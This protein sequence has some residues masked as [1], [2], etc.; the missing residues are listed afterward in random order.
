MPPCLIVACS[1]LIVVLQASVPAWAEENSQKEISLYVESG[2][3]HSARSVA[4]SDDDRLIA[5]G[6]LDRTIKIWDAHSSRELMTLPNDKMSSFL[7]FLPRRPVLAS[8]NEDGTITVWDIETGALI[9]SVMCAH[10]GS[11]IA[12]ADS[13]STLICADEVGEVIRRWNTATFEELSSMPIQMS[14]KLTAWRLSTDGALIAGHNSQ[15]HFE[16]VNL[17]TWKVVGRLPTKKP[18]AI[19]SIAFAREGGRV[20]TNE[21]YSSL[22]AWQWDRSDGRPA[23]VEGTIEAPGIHAVCFS[24]DGQRVAY[25]SESGDIVILDTSAWKETGRLRS[26]SNRIENV[27]LARDSKELAIQVWYDSHF[28]WN[29]EKGALVT[30]GDT[31]ITYDNNHLFEKEGTL[32]GKDFRVINQQDYLRLERE[33]GQEILTLVLLDKTRNWVAV[34]PDGRFDTNMNLA[35]IAGVHW[36]LSGKSL[37]PLPLE[38]FMRDYYEPRLLPRALA[39]ELFSPLPSPTELNRAQPTIEIKPIEVEDAQAGLA[40]VTVEIASDTVKVL[41]EGKPVSMKSG[42]YDL[43]LFRNG[44]LVGQFPDPTDEVIAGE[45]KRD[46]VLAQWR[47]QHALTLDPKTGKQTVTFRGIKLPRTVGLKAVEFSAYAFNV[48]RVKSA[49]A[50][51]TLA[52]PEELTPR[53]GRAYVVTI[54]INRFE[55]NRMPPLT[56]AVND[57]TRLNAELSTRLKTVIDSQTGHP[58]FGETNVIPITL[59]TDFERETGSGVV[60][61]ATKQRIKAVID[62][63]AGKPVDRGWLKSIANAEQLMPAQP[64]DLVVIA[65]STHGDTDQNGEFYLMPSDLGGSSDPQDLWRHAISSEEL[66]AWL[67]PVDAGELVMIVDA[68]HSAATVENQEFKPGPMGSR[69]LGQLAFDKGMR[70][71]AAS[72]RDQYAL[73]TGETQQGLLSYALVREGLGERAADFQPEDGRIQLAEWLTYGVTRVPGLYED[74]RTGKLKPRAATPLNQPEEKQFISI[75][76]PALFDFARGRELTLMMGTR[77][78]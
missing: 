53:Q 61:H 35:D 27:G 16:I 21:E 3:R 33:N 34:A 46:Q 15:G 37:D 57:A 76:Q 17:S 75:Q 70:I 60:N 58:L 12:V 36:V 20:V 13:G 31:A 5:T 6:S 19:D 2:I 41:R 54:G 25:A 66:S 68:C 71:L 11:P 67:R 74:Y 14:E 28:N 43:R 55:H 1:L 40:A 56:F 47:K 72:Q 62:T 39:G 50:R 4:F 44:Q 29:L 18:F 69:G 65:F 38:I 48:D 78:K 51:S 42:A 49:T 9:A 59:V 24:H 26:Y 32:F 63:L 45:Q 10:S 8:A 77:R 52:V 23:H 22:T 30:D 64:E 7:I 73:E